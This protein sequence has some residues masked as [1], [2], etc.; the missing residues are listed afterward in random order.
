MNIITALF[1]RMKSIGGAEKTPSHWNAYLE[2]Q[3]QSVATSVT[4]SDLANYANDYS[5]Y[6]REAALARCVELTQPDLLPIVVGRLNDWVPEVRHA[7]KSALMTLLPVV[8]I[9]QLLATLPSVLRLLQAGRTNHSEWV[10]RYEQNLIQHASVQDLVDAVQGNDIHIAR[11]CFHILK[12]YRFLEPRLLI[13]LFLECR[14]DIMIA[15]QAIQL[16]SELS[17]DERLEL[18]QLAMHS[19]FGAVRTIALRSLLSG[20]NNPTNKGIAIHALFDSQSSVRS[21]AI[22]YLR[23]K[24]LDLRSYYRNKIQEYEHS[25][26]FARIGLAALA[27]LG[28]ADDVAFIQGFV[29]A[30]QPIVRLA[31]LSS[32]LKLDSG[33]KDV[34]ATEALKDKS[35]RVRKF[36]LQM[37]RKHGA[38]IPFEHIRATLEETKDYRLLL[39]FAEGNKWNWLEFIAKIAMERTS[40]AALK[41]YLVDD[42]KRWLRSAGQRYETPTAEQI[43][44]LSSAAALSALADLLKHDSDLIKHLELELP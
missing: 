35:V 43:S 7:A 3:M 25:K 31:A 39:A 14:N 21:L 9:P 12:K 44:F 11:A 15:L 8:P 6:I 1:G 36:A 33:A 18:Y 22:A 23:E 27:S 28:N 20:D 17:E 4:V 26:T 34:I 5:G 29:A 40:T 10:E 32:W 38:Y 2:Q 19:H 42:L 13:R 24:H 37:V 16:A 41:D 30:E